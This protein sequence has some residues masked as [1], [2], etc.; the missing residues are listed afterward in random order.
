MWRLLLS[1]MLVVMLARTCCCM[2]AAGSVH[3]SMAPQ[4]AVTQW[5]PLG[6]K[7]KVLSNK[8]K[9][10]L[11]R[12]FRKALYLFITSGLVLPLAPVALMASTSLSGIYLYYFHSCLQPHEGLKV[13]PRQSIRKYL[14]SLKGWAEYWS[15]KLSTVGGQSQNW[16]TNITRMVSLVLQLL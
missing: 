14:I 16:G 5:S 4:S 9:P 13:A 3:P 15:I 1:L 6:M 10:N 8:V 2:S 12:T 7:G 11:T